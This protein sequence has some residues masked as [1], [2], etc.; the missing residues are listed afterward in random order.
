MGLSAFGR[1]NNLLNPF[2]V[3][4]ELLHCSGLHAF[5]DGDIGFA[6]VRERPFHV[7]LWRASES[8]RVQTCPQH[9]FGRRELL[10]QCPALT[11]DGIEF[12]GV[13]QRG[14]VA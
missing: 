4:C 14:T 11:F 1:L 13:H 10:E 3:A 7:F 8:P 5:I 6:D 9:S 2:K 12:S